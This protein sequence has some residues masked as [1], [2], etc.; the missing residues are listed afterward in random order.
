MRTEPGRRDEVAA[1]L[2]RSA[3]ALRAFGCRSYVVG[4]S[5]SDADVIWVT[6]VWESKEAHDASLDLPEAQDAIAAAMP[7]LTG[8]FTRQ[9]T[10]IVGGLGA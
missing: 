3:D 9:E 1:L 7:L 10:T 6:E 8:E 4:V 5:D 2:L